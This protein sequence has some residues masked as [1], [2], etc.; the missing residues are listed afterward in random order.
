[1]TICILSFILY[2]F[3]YR[4]TMLYDLTLFKAFVTFLFVVIAP[5]LALIFSVIA[6]RYAIKFQFE[7]RGMTLAYLSFFVSALYFMTALAM[8]IVLLGL[9]FMYIY[10]L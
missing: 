6:L 1:S 4:T 5:A 9:Y 3:A 7:M 10:I 8:P 2:V